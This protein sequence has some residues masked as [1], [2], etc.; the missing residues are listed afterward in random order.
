M[1]IHGAGYDAGGIVVITIR[2]NAG[3]LTVADDGA[4]A[5]TAA[6]GTGPQVPALRIDPH[7]VLLLQQLQPLAAAL[8]LQDLP[9]LLDQ[10]RHPPQHPRRWRLPEKQE[11]LVKETRRPKPCPPTQFHRRWRRYSP[12]LRRRD[13]R[14]P[15]VTATAT[16]QQPPGSSQR[17][18]FPRFH[19]LEAG[20]ALLRFHGRRVRVES[21]GS[22]PLPRV[23]HSLQYVDGAPQ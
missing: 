12:F 22:K 9:P 5:T 23:L 16:L 10:R 18:R 6:T 14:P 21:Y 8:L 15:S 2:R 11:N 17:V 19:G 3:V 7:K 4:T 13:R 20:C 1:L